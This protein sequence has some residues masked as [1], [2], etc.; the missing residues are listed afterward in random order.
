LVSFDASSKL[1]GQTTQKEETKVLI[2][3]DVAGE[4]IA[5]KYIYIN[6][7]KNADEPGNPLLVYRTMPF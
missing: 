3:S 2:K 1:I 6:N 7:G 4:G 5:I